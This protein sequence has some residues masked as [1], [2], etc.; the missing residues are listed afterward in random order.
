MTITLGRLLML[1]AEKSTEVTVFLPFHC[2]ETSLIGKNAVA[3][4][5]PELP[6]DYH[7]FFRVASRSTL[8]FLPF[9][10]LTLLKC[11]TKIIQQTPSHPMLL[12]RIL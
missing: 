5:F 7:V 1:C 9:P 3:L 4:D 11:N 10:A 2:M 6:Q 8:S 12:F